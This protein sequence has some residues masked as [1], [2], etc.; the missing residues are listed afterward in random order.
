MAASV[1]E[2]P[3]GIAGVLQGSFAVFVSKMIQHA[4]TDRLASG[5]FPGFTWVFHGFP[6]VQ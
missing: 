4:S 1:D 3:D 5:N 2:R 6:Y